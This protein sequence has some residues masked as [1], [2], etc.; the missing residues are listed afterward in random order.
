MVQE[1]ESVEMGQGTASAEGE[2][3]VSGVWRQLPE[4]L[5][6]SVDGTF[7]GGTLALKHSP[8]HAG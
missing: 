4:H 6:L 5:D 8:I 2:D 3:R 7:D 1:S